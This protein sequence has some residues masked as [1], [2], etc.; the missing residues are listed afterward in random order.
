[1]TPPKTHLFVAFDEDGCP[2][3]IDWA[4]M[5]EEKLVKVL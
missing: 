3:G 2:V 1:M 5:I 4:R